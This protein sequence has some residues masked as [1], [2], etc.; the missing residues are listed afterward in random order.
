MRRPQSPRAGVFQALL[1]A[2]LVAV[3][4]PVRFELM[5][6]VKKAQRPAFR[7]ALSALPVLRPIDETFR[8]LERWIEPAADAGFRFGVTD[9][10]IA[11]LAREIDALVWSIDTDFEAM[12]QLG[13]VQ[14]YAG[15]HE[16]EP[17]RAR[18]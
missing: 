6:G 8:L 18:T 5:S 15:K 16:P 7:R 12:E 1:D 2:D 4:L 11:A 14:L 10:T 17:L 9:L 3:P 13:M